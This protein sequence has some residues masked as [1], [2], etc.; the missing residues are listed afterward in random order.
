MLMK[1]LSSVFNLNFMV[2]YVQH[3]N[4]IILFLLFIENNSKIKEQ[5]K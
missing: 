1:K 4:C 5:E 3:G 2:I